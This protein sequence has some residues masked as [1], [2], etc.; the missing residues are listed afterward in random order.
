MIFLMSASSPTNL[1]MFSCA[2]AEDMASACVASAASSIFPRI[3][4]FTCT[5]SVTVSS[6]SSDVSAS[7]HASYALEPSWPSMPHSSS[8][9]CGAYGPS[10]STKGSSVFRGFSSHLVAALTNSIIAAMAV[11]KRMPSV[12][13]VTFATH[14]L[15]ALS[16]SSEGSASVIFAGSNRRYARARNREHP[17]TPLVCHTF[18]SRSGPMNISYRRSE[19][20]PNSSTTSSGFTTF[21]RDLDILCARADTLTDSSEASTYP[22]PFLVTSSAA[23][24]APS[25]PV[26]STS[27]KIMP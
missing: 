23:I 25:A 19:S 7:G 24:L 21:P 17:S 3:F 20:A 14:A 22:S 15:I 26:Y 13:S 9:R 2:I 12:S 4:P 6:T 5:A 27:P 8:E 10:S 11:L 18:V 16:C 1:A